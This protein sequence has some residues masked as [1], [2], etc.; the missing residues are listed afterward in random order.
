MNV[1]NNNYKPTNQEVLRKHI[2][3]ALL[4]EYHKGTN[5][6]EAWKNIRKLYGDCVS[7][8]TIESWYN[9]FQD[10]SSNSGFTINNEEAESNVFQDDKVIEFIKNNPEMPLEEMSQILSIDI[11]LLTDYKKQGLNN[12]GDGSLKRKQSSPFRPILMRPVSI[13]QYQPPPGLSN[14]YHY[15]SFPFS[16]F[17]A[18]PVKEDIPE[19][20]NQLLEK[21]LG[22]PYKRRK[23]NSVLDK[24]LSESESGQNE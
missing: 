20:K 21:L 4:Y 10:N 14:K 24:L 16:K 12:S 18:Y 23:G 17:S 3:H 5:I 15:Q 22:K 9:S 6:N 8:Y 13:P 7:I 19:V 11:D 2:W 1:D